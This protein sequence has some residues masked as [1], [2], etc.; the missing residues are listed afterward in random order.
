MS[1]WFPGDRACGRHW[2]PSSLEHSRV[3]RSL[4]ATGARTANG[5]L[6]GIGWLPIPGVSSSLFS[7]LWDPEEAAPGKDSR[8]CSDQPHRHRRHEPQKA[9][10]FK[11]TQELREA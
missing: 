8:A 5:A 10:L 11:L 2:L 3:L 1:D 9:D 7:A 6:L 4:A